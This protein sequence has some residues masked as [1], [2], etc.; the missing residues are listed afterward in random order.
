MLTERYFR[1]GGMLVRQLTRNGKSYISQLE[2]RAP[3]ELDEGRAWWQSFLRGSRLDIE[4]SGAD[5][6]VVDAFCGSGG[7]T[8]GAVVGA[9]ALGRKVK[10]LCAV[11]LDQGALSVYAENFPTALTIASNAASLVDFHV[12][13]HGESARFA[14]EPELTHAGLAQ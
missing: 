4:E 1:I 7:F 3:T 8:L 10:P 13:G 5:L 2:D 6:R 9:A 12:Q 14:Y 11:D